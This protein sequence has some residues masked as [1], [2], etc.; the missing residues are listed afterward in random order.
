LTDK[1]H[2]VGRRGYSLQQSLEG[3]T[4]RSDV[5]FLIGKMT[6]LRSPERSDIPL[7]VRWIND[8][9]V[10]RFLGSAFPINEIAEEKWL[11]QGAEDKSKINFVI[12]ML[13]GEAIGAMGFHDI[14]LI[15]RTAFTGAFIGETAFR[16]RGFGTDAK[17]TLLEYAFN[18]LNLHKVKSRALATN[19]ASIAYSLHCGYKK[20]GILR[21]EIFR[22]GQ[23]VDMV[24]LAIFRKDWLP[25]WEHYQET[26][27][28]PKK[29]K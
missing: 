29:T 6:T 25:V 11:T 2:V 24:E 17:L 21:K 1:L 8:P 28:I 7:L 18:T 12:Q 4:M 13:S 9:N 27:K 15:N 5:K 16:N 26:G 22:E 20:E 19:K 10:W 23:Y 14:D 3:K